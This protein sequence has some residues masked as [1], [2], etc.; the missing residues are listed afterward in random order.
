M[1]G[2]I[3]RVNVG[4]F[5]LVAFIG[6][7]AEPSSPAPDDDAVA[8]S[9]VSRVPVVTALERPLSPYAPPAGA[10]LTYYGGKILQNVKVVQVLYGSGTYIPELTSGTP[11]N[12]AGFYAQATTSGVFDWLGSEYDTTS[13]SQR[14][15]RGTFE[16]VV[17]ITPSRTGTTLSPLTDAALKAEL[18]DQIGNG[19]LAAPDNNRIYMVHFPRG[20]PVSMGTSL[21]CRDFCAYHGTFKIGSQDVFYGAMPDISQA[22]CP[23]AYSTTT[24]TSQTVISSH[25]LVEAMTDAEVGLASTLGPPLAWYDA[26]NGEIGDICAPEPVVTF[27]GNDGQTYTIQR[28]FSNAQSA[29][30]SDADI[31]DHCALNHGG[32]D[33]NAA[34]TPRRGWAGPAPAMGG[35]PGT[36]SP[37]AT[38]TSAS[39]VTAAATPTRPAPTRSARG[40]ARAMGASPATA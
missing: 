2:H 36:A 11:P 38:S 3:L 6:C 30:I 25:E 15:G 27:V 40:R 31:A 29:C 21:S 39:R 4:W 14:L 9:V 32:C 22:T 18:A 23:C 37:A 5:A 12:V 19:V 34:C 20:E 8:T 1:M 33:A 10:H 24:F 26:T 28:E 17:Q 35:S 16:G 13:P 7:A